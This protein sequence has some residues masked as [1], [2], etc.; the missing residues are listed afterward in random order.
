MLKERNQN[1]VRAAIPQT[2]PLLLPRFFEQIGFLYPL[3]F[4]LLSTAKEKKENNEIENEENSKKAVQEA[5]DV[6]VFLILT[7][8]DLL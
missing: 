5:C 7:S 6:Y 1:V 4:V 8:L 2:N 3:F